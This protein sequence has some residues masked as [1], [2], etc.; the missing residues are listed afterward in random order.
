MDIFSTSNLICK[1]F[2]IRLALCSSNLRYSHDGAIDIKF[3]RN[4]QLVCTSEAVYGG[5]H[6]T[7]KSNTGEKW[8]TIS[9]YTNCHDPVKIKKG[10]KLTM[11]A[12]YDLTKHKL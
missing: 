2:P 3:F 5:D 10:D 12:D 8:E 4:G 11:T 7:D 6:G 9:S 1:K